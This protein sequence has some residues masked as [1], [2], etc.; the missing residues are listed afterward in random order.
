MPAFF[1]QN[2]SVR[3]QNV[4]VTLVESEEIGTVGVGEA[5]IPL[6][7]LFNAMLGIDEDDFVR[8]TRATFKLGIEFVD[9][10]RR[11]HSYFH[12]FGAYGLDLG[13]ISFQALWQRLR[14]AGK[15]EDL[16]AYS[17]CALAAEAGRF[18][19]PVRDRASPLSQL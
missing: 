10:T 8:R 7:S 5:T 1:R 12:P 13:P 11:G 17:V 6:I 3:E 2:P 4:P 15:A 19:R 9:W 18:S 16:A 14:Q